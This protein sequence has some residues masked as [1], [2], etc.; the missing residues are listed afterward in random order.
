M[1]S[2]GRATVALGSS[3]FE[4]QLDKR[5][6]VPQAGGRYWEGHPVT[7]CSEAGWFCCCNRTGREA[8]E[9]RKVTQRNKM[10]EKGARESTN[11]QR[12][13]GRQRQQKPLISSMRSVMLNSLILSFL[14]HGMFRNLFENKCTQCEPNGAARFTLQVHWPC[15]P[16]ALKQLTLVHSEPLH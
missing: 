5:V 6:W 13:G 12:E 7:H 16:E 11:T 2:W 4:T 10:V 8:G 9:Q 14:C 1:V 3:S 15:V